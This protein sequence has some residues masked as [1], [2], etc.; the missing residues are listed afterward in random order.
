MGLDEAFA[1]LQQPIS[2]ELPCGEDLEDTQL[3]ASFDAYRIFGQLSPLDSREI[4]WREIRER[5]LAALET[6]RDFRLLAH[7]ASAAI[8]LDG[9][10]ALFGALSVAAGWLRDRWDTVYPRVDE[11]AIMRRNALGYFADRMAMIDPLRRLPIVEHRQLGKVSLRDLLM[12]KGEVPVPEGEEAPGE[13]QIGAVFS[14]TGA[15]QVRELDAAF[16][17]AVADLHAIESAMRE[18]GGAA[19]SPEVEPLQALLKRVAAT[20][21]EQLAVGGENAGV[22]PS[23]S[24][25]DGETPAVGTVVAVGSIRSREDALLAMQAVA[26]FFERNEPSSPVPLLLER[27]RRL[28]GK[29]FLEV[30]E[31]IAPEG[32]PGARSAGG[33]RE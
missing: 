28:V 29:S 2:E 27:A 31:E 6:S 15:E 21:R 13:T 3:L 26:R 7:F 18:A 33:I 19:A 24:E 5:S 30:L 32:V 1:R 14:A 17:R 11:D 9:W 4:D 8:R 12:A 25:S 10:P 23:G 22:Q 20:L 16:A